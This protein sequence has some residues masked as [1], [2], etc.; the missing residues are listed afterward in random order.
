MSPIFPVYNIEAIDQLSMQGLL[1]DR[2]SLYL[3][4]HYS[5]LRKPHRHSFYHMVLFTEGDGTHAIDF[6]I[7]RVHPGQ[8]YFMKPGQVHSWDFKGKMDGYIIHFEES[9]FNPFTLEDSVSKKFNFFNGHAKDGVKNLPVEVYQ[10][11]CRLFESILK[12][13]NHPQKLGL[14]LIRLQLWAIFI[15]VS[16]ISND[17]ESTTPNQK[18]VILNNFEMLI[19]KHFN[20][21]RLP[22]QYAALL[23]IT[24]NHLNALCKEM[25]GK[26]AGDLIRERIILE[27]KRLLTN[28]DMTVTQ[29]AYELNYKDN[30]YFNRFFKKETGL[31][32]DD[33]RKKYINK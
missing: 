31:T 5:Q 9:L 20:E 6:Q 22:K 18:K 15:H 2:F 25:L 10:E 21:L 3:E 7:F 8:I 28:A 12:E 29:I 23:F 11:V 16:R 33:F 17:E 24:A 19:E 26:T 4:R 30:S 32:P 1:I 14:E 27:A 13:Y